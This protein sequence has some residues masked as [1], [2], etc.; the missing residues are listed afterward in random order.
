MDIELTSE[1][2]SRLELIAMHAGK[3]PAQILIEAALFLLERDAARPEG[4]AKPQKFLSEDEL[5][6]RF[7]RILGR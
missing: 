3:A 4:N 6:A 2:R 1:Q 7:S 5:N